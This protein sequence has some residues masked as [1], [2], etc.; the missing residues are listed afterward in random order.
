MQPRILLAMLAATAVAVAKPALYDVWDED[1]QAGSL[2]QYDYQEGVD[3]GVSPTTTQSPSLTV[4]PPATTQD[5]TSSSPSTQSGS[6]GGHQTV[7][8]QQELKERPTVTGADLE[9]TGKINLYQFCSLEMHLT[10]FTGC[11]L[12]V[13]L[14][15]IISCIFTF[16]LT[17]SIL[18]LLKK[19]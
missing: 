4:G 19:Q 5:W 3:T 18:K 6:H 13:S 15:A 17:M 12:Y 2:D 8:G 7:P 14:A 10:N 16:S 1:Q 11:T 9:C